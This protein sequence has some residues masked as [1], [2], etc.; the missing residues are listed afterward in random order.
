LLMQAGLFSAVSSA[1]VINI[2][3]KLQPDPSNQAVAL[4]LATL[5]ALN[6]SATLNE[7]V[8][9]PIVRE[10]PPGEIVT[11][12]CFL[13]ASLL[14]SL[15]AAFTAML[16][17]QWLNRYLR[18]VGGS[19]VD[20]CGDR[21]IKCDGLRKWPFHLFIESLPVMLQAALLLLACGLC[22]YMASINTS[23]AA[24]LIGLTLLGVLFYTWIVFAGAYSYACPFQTPAS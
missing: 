5:L 14:I 11:V 7:A 6:H 12:T 17:K 9:V 4:L 22:R 15:L 3:S 10:N 2:H 13:Y 24:V 8:T 19:M 18:H 21:Q 1:F 23:V 20:R 16:G